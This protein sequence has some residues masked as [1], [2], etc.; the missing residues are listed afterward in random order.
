MPRMRLSSSPS[1]LNFMSRMQTYTHEC[2]T[3]PS[4]VHARRTFCWAKFKLSM[5][6]S[7]SVLP[8]RF[9]TAMSSFLVFSVDWY[10]NEGRWPYNNKVT[11]TRYCSL[12]TRCILNLPN[13]ALTNINTRF[14]KSRWT[15]TYPAT[16]TLDLFN[17]AD[18]SPDRL[19]LGVSVRD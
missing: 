3:K 8:F 18:Y 6:R 15:S 12:G 7:S 1:L 17:T 13:C 19:T 11:R 16:S 2:E 4:A 5:R 10:A 9:S 14:I